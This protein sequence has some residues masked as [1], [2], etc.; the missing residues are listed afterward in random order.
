MHYSVLKREAIDNLNIKD[1]GIYVDATLGYAGHSSE[2]LKRIKRGFLFAFDADNTALDYSHQ[3]LISIGSNF[4][5]IHANFMEL[6][7]YLEQ[8]H[9]D[10]VD[11]FLFDLGL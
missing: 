8:E 1:T 10:K 5:L 9:V 2:I 7:S 11:G 3:K 6:E 4:K